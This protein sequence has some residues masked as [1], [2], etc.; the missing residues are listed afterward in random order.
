VRLQRQGSLDAPAGANLAA[1]DDGT[2]LAYRSAV[3]GLSHVVYLDGPPLDRALPHPLAAAPLSSLLFG[4]GETLVYAADG[5]AGGLDLWGA[6]RT[7]GVGRLGGI[8]AAK[9]AG[10]YP[11]GVVFKTDA[12]FSVSRLP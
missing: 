1:N 10:F 11:R 12:G 5:E 4:R 9:E 2:Q 8:L 6:H 3:D 7:H